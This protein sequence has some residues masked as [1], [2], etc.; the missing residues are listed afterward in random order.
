MRVIKPHTQIDASM[1][2]SDVF[3]TRITYHHE[4]YKVFSHGYP[5]NNTSLFVPSEMQSIQ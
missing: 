5:N 4:W 1:H 2:I 3:K